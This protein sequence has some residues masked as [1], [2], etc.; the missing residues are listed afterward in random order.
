MALS[1]DSTLVHILGDEKGRA[2]LDKY[3]P[4]IESELSVPQEVAYS[5]S[6]KWIADFS[7][8]RITDEMLKAI[9]EELSKI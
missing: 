6:L 9:D 3:F 4:N 7:G 5:R 1:V 8:G 2:V